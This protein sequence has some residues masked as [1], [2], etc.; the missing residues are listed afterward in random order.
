MKN[1]KIL[2][3]FLV[4]ISLNFILSYLHY[5]FLNLDFLQNKEALD[6]LTDDKINKLQSKNSESQYVNLI[7]I[8]LS[9]LVKV[10]IVSLVLFIMSFIF[11]LKT[12]YLRLINIVIKLEFIFLL[13]IIYEIIYFKFVNTTATID[14]I[15]YFYP[16]SALNLIGYKGLESY[17]IYPFQVLNLFEL[18]YILLLGYYVGKLAYT[19][20]NKGL[21]MDFGLKIVVSSY[22]PALFLWVAIVMFFTLN[23]S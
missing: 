15:Q 3:L 21:P 11:N 17:F 7:I 13:S 20:K 14:D 23:Y 12:S 4:L 18:A 22:V 2:I 10:L 5:S 6:G 1:K 16:L 19:P 8:A 9:I